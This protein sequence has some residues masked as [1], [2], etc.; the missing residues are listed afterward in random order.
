MMLLLLHPMANILTSQIPRGSLVVRKRVRL[1]EMRHSRTELQLLTVKG[2]LKIGQEQPPEES[3]EHAHGQEEP[4][5]TGHP[6]RAVESKSSARHDTMQVRVIE[7]R[8][9]P[10]V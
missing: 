10:S 2:L 3:R 1:C 8:L 5:P 4:R 9:S 6:A 7:Q